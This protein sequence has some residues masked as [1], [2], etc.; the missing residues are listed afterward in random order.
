LYD[1]GKCGFTKLNFS[2]NTKISQVGA[3]KLASVLKDNQSMN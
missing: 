2:G 1:K 3:V